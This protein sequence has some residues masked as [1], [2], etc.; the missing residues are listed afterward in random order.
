[1]ATF[2]PIAPDEI[3]GALQPENMAGGMRGEMFGREA[4]AGMLPTSDM[5]D[6]ERRRTMSGFFSMQKSLDEARARQDKVAIDMEKLRM[7]QESQR[8]AMR[9]ADI[10]ARKAMFDLQATADKARQQSEIAQRMPQV[11][12]A[13]MDIDK[14]PNLN[15]FD[16]AAEASRLQARVAAQYPNATDFT[17]LFKTYQDVNKAK[18]SEESRGFAMAQQGVGPDSTIEE[19]AEAVQGKQ[20]TSADLAARQ[21]EIK[22]LETQDAFYSTLFREIDQ[23]EKTAPSGGLDDDI[24]FLTGE[25]PKQY[26]EE[27]KQRAVL[28][29]GQIANLLGMN[30]DDAQTFVA[31]AANMD[32]F[33]PDLKQAITNLKFRSLQ[34]QM[35]LYGSAKKKDVKSIGSWGAAPTK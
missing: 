18:S 10:N 25:Q 20:Q 8:M 31:G 28:I 14:N 30:M 7:Q 35:D 13:L 1:M 17:G 21:S 16:K 24:S 29:G 5:T 2:N 34:R 33:I 22:G 12:G 27:S 32:Q 23:L 11:L 19:F 6:A 3:Y 15:T 4:V 9:A 26:S